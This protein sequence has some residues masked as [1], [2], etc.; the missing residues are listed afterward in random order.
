MICVKFAVKCVEMAVKKDVDVAL[1]DVDVVLAF[2]ALA[3]QKCQMTRALLKS[4]DHETN[5][6]LA[7]QLKPR[8]SK[9]SQITLLMFT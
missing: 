1:L 8:G 5:H 2:A 9:I 4:I 3:I 6:Q 7:T